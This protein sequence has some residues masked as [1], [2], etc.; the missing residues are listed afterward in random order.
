MIRLHATVNF[1]FCFFFFFFVISFKQEQRRDKEQ[2]TASRQK[3]NQKG[4][5]SLP[6]QMGYEGGQGGKGKKVGMQ[7][8]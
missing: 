7:P 4:G 1:I 3:N 8:E 6:L 5:G 2:H